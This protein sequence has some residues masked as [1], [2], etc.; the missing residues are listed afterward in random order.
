MLNDDGAV[1][2][3]LPGLA[4][5]SGS[6]RGEDVMLSDALAFDL[7]VYD[8]NAPL[9][10]VRDAP[11][12]A[13]SETRVVLEP[14]DP[15]WAAAYASADNMKSDGTGA[16]GNNNGGTPIYPFVGTGAYV[17]LGYG[18]NTGKV[19]VSLYAP[20]YAAA[21]SSTGL[22]WF[23]A[24]QLET[25]FA[26]GNSRVVTNPGALTDVYNS[27][28]AP[29]YAV[30]DTWSFHYE[31]DGVNEDDD[32]I[33]NGIWQRDNHNGVGTPLIDQ[34]TNGLD[35]YGHYYDPSI[36]KTKVIA[37]VRNGP[38]DVGERETAPPYDKPLRGIKVILRLYE[39]DSRQI[40]QV[41]VDQHFVP[42]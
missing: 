22:P 1:V 14:T 21:Y 36:D 4:P 32:E 15:A 33:E 6:R 5:L 28:L 11:V 37:D 13:N 3:V 42:E 7:R 12:T 20:K 23:F 27:Q 17:D 30:Y 31:N 25:Q 40:R 24:P 34:G 41:S 18:F 10:G 2:R 26:V 9:F 8:P 29:G 38:D 35:D 19:G 16:I 39:R